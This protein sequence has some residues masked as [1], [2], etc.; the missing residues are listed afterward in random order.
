MLLY[1]TM[2]AD[3]IECGARIFDFGRSSRNTGPHH[4]KRQWGA[5][6][7]PLH[8]EYILLTRPA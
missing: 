8:W 1:W 4:F 6:E 3:A 5:Q 7:T 2:L